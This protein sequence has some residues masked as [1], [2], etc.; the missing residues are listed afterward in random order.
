VT[1]ELY[2]LPW[3]NGT[4][5]LAVDHTQGMIDSV[6][7]GPRNAVICADW[8]NMPLQTS[9]RDIVLCDGGVHLMT[10]PHEQRQFV[11]TLHRVI[12]SDGLFIS[13]LFIPPKKREATGKVLQDLLEAKIPNLNQLKFR[14][15]MAMHEDITH[16][17]ELKRIWNAIHGVA[18]D[19]NRLASRIGW[20]LE[21]LMAINTYRNSSTRYYFLDL[22]DFCHLFCENPG[23][24]TLESVSVPTYELG[25]QCPTV[26][27][28]RIDTSGIRSDG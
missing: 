20:P 8:T 3:P 1:P 19:F 9:S 23:G 13:R 12:A 15:W 21:H 14:L 16:G 25:E 24:F 5:L 17:V 11:R 10:Y 26:A 2:Y 18:P 7:P 22:D 4:D 27:L 6:W 28:R